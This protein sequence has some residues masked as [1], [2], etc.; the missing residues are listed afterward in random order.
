[1]GCHLRERLKLGGF[2]T[3]RLWKTK[4]GG[5]ASNAGPCGS[6]PS[7]IT[8]ILSA[9]RRRARKHVAQARRRLRGFAIPSGKTA[10]R[11][12]RSGL[13]RLLPEV[14]YQKRRGLRRRAGR[15]G[16]CR[17]TTTMSGCIASPGLFPWASLLPHLKCS[18]AMSAVEQV[19]GEDQ[20]GD[21]RRFVSSDG[22]TVSKREPR[23]T[24]SHPRR[25][26]RALSGQ[27][28]WL[29]SQLL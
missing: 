7:A 14:R 16:G 4:S 15:S 5:G 9:G 22:R 23:R 17:A 28:H 18:R 26:H 8:H 27:M 6:G 3:F 10:P 20:H 13:Q 2:R 21:A 24:R 12:V 19:D 11:L 1:M 25:V 29:L